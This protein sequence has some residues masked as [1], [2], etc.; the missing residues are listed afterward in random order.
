MFDGFPAAP[1]DADE[2]QRRVGMEAAAKARAALD[3]MDPV[4]R[5]ALQLYMECM[6]MELGAQ[7]ADSVL[8]QGHGRRAHSAA[9]QWHMP[10]YQ[11]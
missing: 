8:G 5:R 10:P 2:A 1:W 9:N 3:S 7:T 11:G 4:Q 6:G